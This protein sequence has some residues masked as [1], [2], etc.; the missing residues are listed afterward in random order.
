M[1][2]ATAGAGSTTLGITYLSKFPDQFFNVSIRPVARPLLM[3]K[4][5]CSINEVDSH[6]E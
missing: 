1:F 5:F 2:V 3:S 4:I 6:N